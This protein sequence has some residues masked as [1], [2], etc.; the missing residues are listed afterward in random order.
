ML[1]TNQCASS[2]RRRANLRVVSIHALGAGLLWAALPAAPVHA[3]ASDASAAPADEGEETGAIVITGSRRLARSVADVAAPV[4]IFT[5]DDLAKQPS[6]DMGNLLRAIV[7]SLNVND[8]PISGTSAGVRPVELRGLSPDSTLVLINGKRMNRSAD[9]PTFSGGISDGSQS[10]DISVL[11][12]IA[13]KQV[14]V[15]RDGAAA[16]YGADAIAGVVNF[17]MNDEPTGGTIQA[18]F[19]STYEGDGNLYEIDGTY[20]LSLGEKGFIRASVEYSS[21]DRAIRAVQRSDAAALPAQGF[22]DVPDPATRFGTPQVHGNLKIF[23]NMAVENG[24]GGEFYAFGG[25]N[26][27]TAAVD[28]FYRTP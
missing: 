17:I 16:Q 12:S 13:L 22:T 1:S 21:Q 6:T 15:L 20:G 7:P 2:G 26:Q 25:Y 23:A 28:F 24:L 11:P 19:G 18:K 8:N 10:P 4:D 5:A 3:Q 14:Q 27:R 9:I